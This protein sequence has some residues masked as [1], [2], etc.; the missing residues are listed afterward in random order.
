MLNI[1]K[2]SAVVFA[3]A[4]LL[5]PLELVFAE[6][7]DF[8]V[9]VVDYYG[10]GLGLSPYDDP[11]A[12]LGSPAMICKELGSNGTFRA[13]LVEAVYNVDISGNKV[14]TTIEPKEYSDDPNNFIT[15][16]FDHKVVDYPGN[17][18]GADFIVFG[19]SAFTGNG[20]ISDATNLNTYTLNGGGIF[21]KVYVSV[22]QY[23][24][25]PWYSFQG[26]PYGDALFPTQAYFWDR[27]N[28]QWT[29]DEMDF[30]RPVDPN[31]TLAYFNNKSAA[32]AIDLY[33]GSGG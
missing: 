21:E 12:V 13:K 32:D 11:D 20:N 28:A 5:A 22:S 16:R 30:T 24:D 10:D 17:L 3:V 31:L 29:D 9:E 15:V 8:A 14:I 25:G 18:F 33:D 26:G 23:P 4:F 1:S 27:E 6:F 19:N 7:S 2:A